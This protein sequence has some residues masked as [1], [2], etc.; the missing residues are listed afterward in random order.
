[1]NSNI[2]H[3]IRKGAFT[4]IELAVVIVL[5]GFIIGG[6]LVGRDMIKSSEIRRAVSSLEA[7]ATGV[8]TFKIKYNCLPGDCANATEFMGSNYTQLLNV[9][10]TGNGDGNGLIDHWSPGCESAQANLILN[11]TSMIPIQKKSYSINALAFNNARMV[12]YNDSLG[13]LYSGDVYSSSDKR[14]GLSYGN[15]NAD[16]F[17]GASMPPNDARR[18]DEKIDNNTPGSGTFKAFDAAPLLLSD[19]GNLGTC[20]AAPANA[21]RTGNSY[22]SSETAGC[23]TIYYLPGN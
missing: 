8:N 12:G 3:N 1:M 11:L 14:L 16:C 5:I 15:E 18:I 23:R 21:C 20:P 13:Y 9:F 22:A 10:C 17:N 7:V 6:V 2:N 4:L 19:P